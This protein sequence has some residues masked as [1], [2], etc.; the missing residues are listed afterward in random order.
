MRHSGPKPAYLVSHRDFSLAYCS[1]R[2]TVWGMA[3]LPSNQLV[4][5]LR[6]ATILDVTPETVA[7]WRRRGLIPAIT[8]NRTTIRYDVADV[9]ASL[10]SLPSVAGTPVAQ[11]PT[12]G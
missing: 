8:I 7:L 1:V 6:L 4:T 10:K 2:R 9:L 11:E 5:A 3:S 12:N